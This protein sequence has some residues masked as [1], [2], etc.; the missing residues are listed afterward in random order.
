MSGKRGLAKIFLLAIALAFAACG[1]PSTPA[2]LSVINPI[3]DFP[4][5]IGSYWVYSHTEYSEDYASTNCCITIVVVDNQMQ[6]PYFL[7][8]LKRDLSFVPQWAPFGLN[9]GPGEF[10]YAL[11]GRGH[12]YYLADMAE[13]DKI[14]DATLAFVFP[15][16]STECWFRSPDDWNALG[17]HCTFFAGPQTHATPAGVFEDCYGSVTPYLS[18]NTY[19]IVCKGIG[20]VAAQYDH[21]GSPFGYETTLLEYRIARP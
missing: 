5:T 11:D 1:A 13:I 18:G 4:L 20:Y 6:G 9:D 12:V 15:L 8:K 10:W 7:A 2:P 14:E 21:W 19:E 16:E 17:D 3:N